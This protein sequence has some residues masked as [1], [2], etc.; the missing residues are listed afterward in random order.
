M[1]CL[2]RYY[3]RA[4]M[5]CRS[6]NPLF[7]T[8]FFPID[9]EKMLIKDRSI[10]RVILNFEFYCSQLQIFKNQFMKIIFMEYAAK[11]S[12][13]M[14]LQKYNLLSFI[15]TLYHVINNTNNYNMKLSLRI[16]KKYAAWIWMSYRISINCSCLE[17][18]DVKWQWHRFLSKICFQ[19]KIAFSRHYCFIK[20]IRITE[21][22]TINSLGLY[23]EGQPFGV[24]WV[25]SFKKL[26]QQLIELVKFQLLLSY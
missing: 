5:R 23:R 26:A 9:P 6:L 11:P 8:Y 10:F 1:F 18:P 15:W 19:V 7:P 4:L 3:A 2:I 12:C 14:I 20:H 21:I 16:W 13:V 22:V 17:Q 24:R 25:T